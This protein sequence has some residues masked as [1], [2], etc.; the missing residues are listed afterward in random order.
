MP[1][2]TVIM[3]T[4]N[5]AT[6]LPYSIGSAL[7]QTFTD[8]E[9]LVMGDGCTD[10]SGSVV[11]SM[12]D[13]RVQWCDLTPRVGHQSGPN[14]E[15]IRRAKGEIIAYMGHDDLWLPNHLSVLV[16]AI[17][18]GARFVF[19]STLMINPKR[20]PVRWPN[21]EWTYS[22]GEWIP[23]TTVAHERAL[24]DAI[25]GWRHPRL[26]GSLD[27][28]GDLWRRMS[29]YCEPPQRQDE[30]TSLK[31]SA[32]TREGVYRERPHHEQ[33]YWLGRI[34][35]GD[36]LHRARRSWRTRTAAL[37]R[38]PRSSLQVRTRL[39]RL[40]IMAPLPELSGEDRWRANARFKGA[41]EV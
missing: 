7:G 25:G 29:E 28:E 26:T 37:T 19:G 32:S 6:V 34:E 12:G 24:I 39:R 13:P 22:P 18:G 23:P 40:G 11:T 16:R 2:V 27:S 9:L 17:D 35:A 38:G 30:L 1:R 8:F 20:R 31:L 10:D 33:E 14:N 21:K 3:A 36:S 41:E 15:G 5:W 4:H